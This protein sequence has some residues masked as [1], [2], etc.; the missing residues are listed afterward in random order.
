MEER[1][2]TSNVIIDHF[3]LTVVN[4]SL[5]WMLYFHEWLQSKG[6][7]L[8][9]SESFNQFGIYQPSYVSTIV[10]LWDVNL[11]N[12]EAYSEPCQ[13]PKMEFFAKIVNG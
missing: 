11:S 9:R 12:P 6:K 7:F 5:A 4:F 1:I 2:K 13:I 10:E 8:A 3:S